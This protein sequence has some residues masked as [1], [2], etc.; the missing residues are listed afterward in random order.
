MTQEKAFEILTGALQKIKDN[1]GVAEDYIYLENGDLNI[2]NYDIALT[3][4]GFDGTHK[5]SDFDKALEDTFQNKTGI[6]AK[7]GE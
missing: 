2:D 6:E 4:L 7:K 3:A 1:G 5:E